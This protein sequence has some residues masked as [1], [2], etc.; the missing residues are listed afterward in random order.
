MQRY[1]IIVKHTSKLVNYSCLTRMLTECRLQ[2]SVVMVDTQDRQKMSCHCLRGKACT[3]SD[4][5]PIVDSGRAGGP[6]GP[7]EEY[8]R[9]RS[10][11][12][13]CTQAT[14]SARLKWSCGSKFLPTPARWPPTGRRWA[15]TTRAGSL[16][17]P[18]C[19]PSAS[20]IRRRAY[21][22][23]QCHSAT[24]FSQQ[25]KTLHDG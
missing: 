16:R 21:P 9:T 23:T 6:R 18:S 7:L 3:R 4:G 19:R 5:R 1:S 8:W 2:L 20:G 24:A 25:V 10:G 17:K 13:L 11:R 12:D 22:Y 14:H 15:G